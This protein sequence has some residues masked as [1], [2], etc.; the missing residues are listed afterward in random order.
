MELVET[1][2]DRGVVTLILN[3]PQRR[4]ALDPSLVAHLGGALRRIDAD[5]DARVVVLSGA[6]ENFCAGGDIEWMKSAAEASPQENEKDALALEEMFG[7]LDQLSKP[8]VA[9][10][11]GVAF[12][13]GVGLVAC[14]DISLAAKS[15]KFCLSEVRLGLIPA[16]VGPYVLRAIGARAMRALALS[17]EIVGADCAFHVGLVHEVA[18]EDGLIAARDRI[19]EALLLGAPGAQAA[20]KQLV[21]ICQDRIPDAS[22][23]RETARLLAERRSSPEG[24]EGLS[25]FLEKRAPIWRAPRSV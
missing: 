20:V 2:D 19:V 5:P 1:M 8:T 3:R 18:R 15:A 25:G 16:V 22:L 17:A 11:Q 24:V 9:L 10:V 23:S 6:G 14:C 4:N 21:R 13:G 12:G 7:A